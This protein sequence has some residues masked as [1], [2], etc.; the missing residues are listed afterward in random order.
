MDGGKVDEGYKCAYFFMWQPRAVFIK[1]VV[2]KNDK[3]L[4]TIEKND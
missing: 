2:E 1:E 4:K 3:K